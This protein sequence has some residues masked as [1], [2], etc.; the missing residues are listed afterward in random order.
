MM[1]FNDTFSRLLIFLTI[2]SAI[3]SIN[4]SAEVVYYHADSLGSP[5]A[6]TDENGNLLWREH[7]QPFGSRVEV[8]DSSGG[9]R[10]WF[11]GKNHDDETGLTYLGA[12]HYDPVI[13]RFMGVDPISFTEA[14]PSS[15]NRYAYAANNPYV[16]TDPSGE[17]LNFVIGGLK[18]AAESII[19]QNL[20]IKLGLRDEFSW[21]EFAFDAGSGVATSGLSGVKTAANIVE[22]SAEVRKKKRAADAADVVPNSTLRGSQNPVVRDAAA[23]GRQ[24]HRE[25]DYGPGFEREFTLPSGRRADA[26]NLQTNEVVELKPNNPR[27]I[28]RGERQVEGYRQELEDM[29]GECFTCRVVTYDP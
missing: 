29:T 4:A 15:F 21:G 1:T 13:G 27:A 8:P 20:E 22:M 14:V 16:F 12:R 23:R 6:A 9:N 7:F 18:G 19:V 25:Y 10:Q 3:M 26:V 2:A 17:F 28:R 24:A 5:I 11:L